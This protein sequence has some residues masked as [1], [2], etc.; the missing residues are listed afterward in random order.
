MRKHVQARDNF[1]TGNDLKVW[2]EQLSELTDS[3]LRD[4]F[5]RIQVQISI[6][7]KHTVYQEVK[8]FNSGYKSVEEVKARL[9]KQGDHKDFNTLCV[10]HNE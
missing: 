8:M 7:I 6:I 4:E 5:V 2:A 10:M 3:A 1:I 9:Y